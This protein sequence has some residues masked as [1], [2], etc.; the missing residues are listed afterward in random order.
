MVRAR[1]AASAASRS[2][3]AGVEG[4]SSSDEHG[5]ELEEAKTHLPTDTKEI[6]TC[7]CGTHA[8]RTFNSG[9]LAFGAKNMGFESGFS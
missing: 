5:A 8:L 1:R 2:R 7:T 6:A 4:S 9:S 3:A